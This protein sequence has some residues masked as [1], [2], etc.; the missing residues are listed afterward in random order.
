MT[1]CAITRNVLCMFLACAR[2]AI[3]VS[4]L[5]V[6]NICKQFGPRSGLTKSRAWSGS[7]LFAIHS[8]SIPQKLFERILSQ[9]KQQKAKKKAC[10]VIQHAHCTTL[11]LPATKLPSATLVSLLFLVPCNA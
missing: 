1:K 10:T 3:N 6:D 9:V 2:L 7:E 4:C 11:Y 8:D 5:S